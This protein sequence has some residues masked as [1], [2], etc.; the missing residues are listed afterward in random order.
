[1][2]S[3]IR[4]ASGSTHFQARHPAILASLAMTASALSARTDAHRCLLFPEPIT[5]LESK[6]RAE[7]SPIIGV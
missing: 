4:I 1:V 7:P 6:F 3:T 5:P 2:T